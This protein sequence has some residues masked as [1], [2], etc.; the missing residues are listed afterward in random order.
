M[1]VRTHFWAT[2]LIILGLI[3]GGALLFL[4][5]T[6][7]L[8]ISAEEEPVPLPPTL[9]LKYLETP[10]QVSQSETVS[11]EINIVN[12]G[13]MEIPQALLLVQGEGV[14][15]SS[16]DGRE[17][18][19]T[20]SAYFNLKTSDPG[21]ALPLGKLELGESQTVKLSLKVT[22]SD[23]K[24]VKSLSKLFQVETS[25]RRCGFLWLKRC[26]ESAFMRPLTEAENSFELKTTTKTLA[27]RLNPGY[28]FITL[29][30]TLTETDLKEF[31]KSFKIG[32]VYHYEPE[33]GS[34][35][36]ARALEN[37]KNLLEGENFKLLKPGVGFFV[38]ETQTTSYPLP[39]KRIAPDLSQAYIISLKP[40]FNQLG[41]PFPYRIRFFRD[42]IL[43]R[44]P[45]DTTYA[46]L[47]TFQEAVLRGTLA[48]PQKF[49]STLQGEQE[50]AQT[51][52]VELKDRQFLAPF[53][54][55]YLK[56]D[57]QIDLVFP[58]RDLLAP[59]EFLTE[60]EK[61][62]ISRW[63]IDERLDACGNPPSSL[64]SNPLYDE[65][66]DQVLD[67]FDCLLLNHPERPWL[68]ER[69]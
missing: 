15:H 20:E 11:F 7:R 53:Q 14:E 3:L 37:W 36:E 9:S 23:S 47:V 60:E 29:P 27:L 61:V 13:P 44:R 33:E 49:V 41:N 64:Q 1:K 6:G 63:L 21:V 24:E 39:K 54:G 46:N 52:F 57:E 45:S 42:K 62:R 10:S 22:A 51:N 50:L 69:V 31:L 8:V 43:V 67:Q 30:F 19:E 48:V 38:Y 59:S 32:W 25:S 5:L 26:Q 34:P 66:L 16:P 2:I 68:K 40:G 56:A 58:G 4:V 17:L 18:K 12:S 55:F 35:P 65:T 28:N